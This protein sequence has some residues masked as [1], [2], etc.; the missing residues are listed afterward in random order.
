MKLLAAGSLA[1][2]Q[3]KVPTRACQITSGHDQHFADEI[4]SNFVSL[5]VGLKCVKSSAA[6]IFGNDGA[7]L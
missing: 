6:L 4:W 2:S 1:R 7:G 5:P 3:P